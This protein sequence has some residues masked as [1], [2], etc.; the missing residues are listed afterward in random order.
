MRTISREQAQLSAY[1][2]LTV[3]IHTK[4]EAAI[5]QSIEGSMQGCDAVWISTGPSTV[6]LARRASDI[7]KNTGGNDE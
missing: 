6:Q 2:S 5:V 1:Q 7:I 3:D 4:R